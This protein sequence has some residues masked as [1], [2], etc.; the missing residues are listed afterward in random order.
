MEK[1]FVVCLLN[2]S[3]L[4]NFLNKGMVNK[5]PLVLVGFVYA[6]K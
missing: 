4:L 1:L 2:G 5:N 3:G 6:K